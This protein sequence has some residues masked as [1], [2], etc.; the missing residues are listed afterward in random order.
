MLLLRVIMLLLL[1]LLLLL[2]YRQDVH[3]I[4]QARPIHL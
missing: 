3:W 2:P 4:E 1:L